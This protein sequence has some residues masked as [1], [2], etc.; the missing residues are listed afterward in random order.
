M[1]DVRGTTYAPSGRGLIQEGSRQDFSQGRAPNPLFDTPYDVGN[2]Y[3]QWALHL[4]NLV[5]RSDVYSM[6][7]CLHCGGNSACTAK[8]CV[9]CRKPS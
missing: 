5:S 4:E 1:G 2:K 8:V 6:P 3:L 7:S 9:N